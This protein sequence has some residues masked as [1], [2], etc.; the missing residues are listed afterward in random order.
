MDL[1]E[2][3]EKLQLSA[4]VGKELLER[5]SE[6]VRQNEEQLQEF[7]VRTEVKSPV[8]FF[9]PLEASPRG[10]IY[11]FWD[12]FVS[13]FSFSR[14]WSSKTTSSA[15]NYAFLNSGKGKRKRSCERSMSESVKSRKRPRRRSYS[16]CGM[17]MTWSMKWRDSV[18]SWKRR[19]SCW[20]IRRTSVDCRSDTQIPPSSPSVSLFTLYKLY[21]VFE[22]YCTTSLCTKPV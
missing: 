6:L 14:N 8:M 3:H 22:R 2:L 10:Q 20:S 7:S 15:L 4:Q 1:E 13:L 18:T 12:L 17:P 21:C 5:N 9:H 11:K 19:N 16:T